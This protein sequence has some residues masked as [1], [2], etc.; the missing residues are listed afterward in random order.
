MFESLTKF[1]DKF[2]IESFGEVPNIQLDE[3]DDSKVTPFPH[4]SYEAVVYEFMDAVYDF[5]D[6]NNPIPH[7]DYMKVI[8]EYADGDPEKIKGLD[9]KDMPS[10]VAFAYILMVIRGE[11]F[12]DGLLLR[13]LEDG[14]IIKWLN[15]LKEI[16]ENSK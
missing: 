16:D 7:N 15:R 14:T 10:N 11:R 13:N 9:T 1:I 12:C 8:E 3:D 6:N 5:N 4:V 2:N